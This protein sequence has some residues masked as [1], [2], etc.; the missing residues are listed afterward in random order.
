MQKKAYQLIE[1]GL[2]LLLVSALKQKR[3]F[4]FSKQTLSLPVENKGSA[5]I[6]MP[7]QKPDQFLI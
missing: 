4:I 2:N 5:I 6:C 1:G 7:L 3:G